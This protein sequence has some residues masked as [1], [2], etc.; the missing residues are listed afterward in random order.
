MNHATSNHLSL[1]FNACQE[2]ICKPIC[3][4]KEIKKLIEQ[5][6]IAWDYLYIKRNPK[7]TYGIYSDKRKNYK[8][9]DEFLQ[10][11][12]I[13]E[14]TLEPTEWTCNRFALGSKSATLRKN[15][16]DKM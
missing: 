5:C 9:Q 11:V 1:E 6:D 7:L 3:K 2:C 14:M 8:R 15:Y 10:R 12:E 13:L 16:Y 4:H